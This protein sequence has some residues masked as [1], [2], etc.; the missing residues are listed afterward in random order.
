MQKLSLW[1]CR[2]PREPRQEAPEPP[3]RP[4]ASMDSVGQGGERCRYFTLYQ[5]GAIQTARHIRQSVAQSVT[6]SFAPED[7]YLSIKRLQ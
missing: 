2:H 5:K 7:M 4:H 6:P 3:G 1:L